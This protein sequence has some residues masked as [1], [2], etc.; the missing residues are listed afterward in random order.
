MS[1]KSTSFAQL[2]D[3]MNRAQNKG[4]A[5][6]WNIHGMSRSQMLQ[7]FY[8]NAALLR[9]HAK[10][11]ILYHEIISLKH[12]PSVSIERQQ[13]ALYDLAHKYLASR[14]KDLLGYGRIH[15]E[16]GHIHMHLM[17]SSNELSK[18]KRHR[19]SKEAF[20]VIQQQCELYIQQTYPELEQ[21]TIYTKNYTK[22]TPPT[23]E[24][25]SVSKTE[26]KTPTKRPR[27]RRRKELD[28]LSEYYQNI[29]K[30][31]DSPEL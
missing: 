26:A 29:D 22:K 23:V 5:L 8:D 10:G 16:K 19:L 9:S 11:N 27:S 7:S 4:D 3:Y 20:R 14:G 6:S 15:V 12:C 28:D 31:L 30:D 1:R 13:K 24:G 2:F 25:H 17:L 18:S 21:Q